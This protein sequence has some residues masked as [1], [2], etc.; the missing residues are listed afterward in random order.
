MVTRV[1]PQ[2]HW[3]IRIPRRGHALFSSAPPILERFNATGHIESLLLDGQ[4]HYFG[5]DPVTDRILSPL[6]QDPLEMAQFA[7]QWMRGHAGPRDAASWLTEVQA[8]PDRPHR[9]PTPLLVE[10]RDLMAVEL[11]L[12]HAADHDA[13]SCID[14][15]R[16]VVDLLR[17]VYGDIADGRLQAMFDWA[18]ALGQAG[19]ADGPLGWAFDVIHGVCLAPATLSHR[20]IAV[21]LRHCLGSLSDVAVG[22]WIMVFGAIIRACDV[23]AATPSP[24]PAQVSD[25]LV[26]DR[27]FEV[28]A[29]ADVA[30]KVPETSLYQ[31]AYADSLRPDPPIV[32][33][34]DGDLHL[35]RLDLDDPLARWRR[36]DADVV[37]P[38]FILV[39]GNFVIEQHLWCMETDGSCGLVA[40]GDLTAR[41][42]IVGGQQIHVGGN[43]TIEELYWGDYNHGCLHVEGDT[44]AALLIQTDYRMGLIGKVSCLKRV[45]DL[46][47]LDGDELMKIIA[48]D[49]VIQTEP[50]PAPEW[51]LNAA[52]MIERLEAGRSVICREALERPDPPFTIPSLFADANVSPG[53]FL[54]LSDPDLLPDDGCLHSIERDGLDLTVMAYLSEEHCIPRRA[55]LIKDIARNI[56]VSF[57]LEPATAPWSWRDVVSLRKPQ[58]GWVLLKATCD[59]LDTPDPDW[60]GVEGVTFTPEYTALILKGWAALLEWASHRHWAASQIPADRV[61][62]LLALPVAAPYDDYEDS[63]RN[64]LWTGR[65]H[66]AFR[67]RGRGADAEGQR[68]ILRFSRSR[69]CRDTDEE[70]TESFYYVL[71]RCQDGQERVR[72]RH[73]ADQ[74]SEQPSMPLDAEGGPR[75]VEA[76][77]LFHRAA[78]Q[79]EQVNA[80]LLE[81]TPPL[82]ATDDAFAMRHWRDRGYLSR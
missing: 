29:Y 78:G 66:A 53:N 55:I 28:V 39:T 34:V 10:E 54:R 75:L 74:E 72:V 60:V 6:I 79:L 45:D 71:E 46:D 11:A 7:V 13:P 19:Q 27:P 14:L 59:T 17:T 20:D 18:V 51:S 8:A 32:L 1:T 41:N 77:R 81:G 26:D 22:N 24:T 2:G 80:A 5:H 44:V 38:W 40:L 61:R 52:A 23:V 47:D 30:N 56:G 3:C 50:E 49:C 65:F 36:P 9:W 69:Y 70:T 16:N 25:T 35:D 82:H 63:D 21:A 62:R 67:Q 73:L 48:A 43:L 37:L 33:F 64:G 58:R 42:A 12:R 57:T 4:R 15:R 31:C 76:V 68:P